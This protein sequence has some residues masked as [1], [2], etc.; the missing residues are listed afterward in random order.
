MNWQFVDSYGNISKEPTKFQ[1]DSVGNIIQL[2]GA[3]KAIACQD[4][5]KKFDYTQIKKEKIQKVPIYECENC[6]FK[7]ASGDAAFDHKITSDHK[8]KK[9]FADRIVGFVNKIKGPIAIINKTDND[10]NILCDKCDVS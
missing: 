5:K 4:C 10:V 2:S 7:N 9:T 3:V 8:I 6:D 1:I